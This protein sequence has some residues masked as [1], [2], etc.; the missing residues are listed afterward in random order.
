MN[1]SLFD[2]AGPVMV[3]P[4]SSHTAGA[5]RLARVARSI[6][7]APFHHVSFGLHGSFAKTYQGHGTDKALV[8]GALGMREDDE[9]LADAF[10]IARQQGLSYEFYETDLEEMHENSVLIT[11]SLEGGGACV[12]AGS[13]IGGG[14]IVIRR[15]NEFEIE[16][17]ALA[18]TLLIVQRDER[19]VVSEVTGIL[20]EAGLNIG[21][22]RVSR[23]AKG[24]TAFC[25]IE[26][27]D[28]VAAAIVTQIRAMPQILHVQAIHPD[29]KEEEDVS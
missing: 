24:D 16:F 12:V 10:S 22:M 29:G 20:A 28:R 15:V 14:Q 8:A 17:Q 5:A 27:D 1:I 9:R 23:R 11:F 26:L 25:V 13:S 18:P 7:A 4:S 3:G 19:G 6:A 21:V 2:V